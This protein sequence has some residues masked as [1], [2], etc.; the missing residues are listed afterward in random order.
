MLSAKR[1]RIEVVD[2]ITSTSVMQ[3]LKDFKFKRSKRSVQWWILVRYLQLNGSEKTCGRCLPQDLVKLGDGTDQTRNLPWFSIDHAYFVLVEHWRHVLFW[4]IC[5]SWIMASSLQ[6]E[7]A[8]QGVTPIPKLLQ[9][10]YNICNRSSRTSPLELW[11][12]SLMISPLP[13]FASSQDMGFQTCR[14]NFSDQTDVVAFLPVCCL[15]IL[16]S[17]L[18]ASPNISHFDVWLSVIM[19]CSSPL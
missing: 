13:K 1:T 6:D 2:S 3:Q 19:C 17:G 12:A 11:R 16:L 4:F 15:I 7:L 9:I 5:M 10:L 14:E 8:F 18:K